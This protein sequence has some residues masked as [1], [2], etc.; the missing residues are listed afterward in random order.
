MR[1][2]L[3]STHQQEQQQEQQ[4]QEKQQLDPFDILNTVSLSHTHT[5]YYDE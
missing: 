4:P 3:G 2:V 5:I 1:L